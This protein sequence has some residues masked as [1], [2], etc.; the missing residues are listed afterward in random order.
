MAIVDSE[1]ICNHDR[2]LSG[3]LLESRGARQRG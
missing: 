3:V 2:F 1:R